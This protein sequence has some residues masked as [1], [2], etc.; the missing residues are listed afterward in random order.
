MA[1]SSLALGQS[2]GAATKE[3]ANPAD[4]VQRITIILARELRDRLPPLSLLDFPPED[5]GTAGAKLAIADNNT[6]GRFLKQE[7]ALE[8][9]ESAPPEELVLRVKE[10]AAAGVGFVVADATPKT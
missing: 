3:Q 5:E 2:A 9:L 1:L 10:N 6:T 4:A 7:F 8:V